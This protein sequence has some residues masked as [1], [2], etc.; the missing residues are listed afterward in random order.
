MLLPSSSL[1]RPS[2]QSSSVT[3]CTSNKQQLNMLRYMLVVW[4]LCCALTLLS[5][6]SMIALLA[7]AAT[8]VVHCCVQAAQRSCRMPSPG[9][10]NKQLLDMLR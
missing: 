4:P 6:A 5:P 8:T 3:P 10:T 1:E 7:L 9:T 2:L